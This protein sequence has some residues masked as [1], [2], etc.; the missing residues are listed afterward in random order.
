MFV[1]VTVIPFIKINKVYCF[2]Q[3]RNTFESKFSPKTHI[4]EEQNDFL[5]IW[6]K[7]D[8]TK[9]SENWTKQCKIRKSIMRGMFAQAL[10]FKGIAG[11]EVFFPFIIKVITC[12]VL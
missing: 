12:T 10:I 1:S 2:S 8:L 4:C 6:H 7:I 3:K 9:P 5:W 11:S